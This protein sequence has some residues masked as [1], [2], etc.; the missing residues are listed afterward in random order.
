[1]MKQ[2]ISK[3]ERQENVRQSLSTLRSMIKDED[4]KEL[5]YTILTTQPDLFL[6]TLTSEDAKTRK[7]AA[8]L[9]GDLGDLLS[10]SQI[11]S[12]KQLCETFTATLF[13]S[14]DRETTLFVKSAYLEA[15]KEYDYTG[16]LPQ[17]KERLAALSSM[18]LAE[19]NRKHITEEIH[20]LTDMIVS[21]EGI[22]KHA[23]TGFHKE[24]ECIFLTNRLHRDL[25]EGQL[26]AL[27][28][29]PFKPFPAGV[30]L[31]TRQLDELLP[32]RT[33][34]EVLFL[35]PGMTTLPSDPA[36]AAVK[37]CE[38]TLLQFLKERHDGT[39]PFYFRVEM[40]SKMPLDKK[41]QFI[42][43]FASE[44][45]RV[46]HRQLINSKANYELELRL[47][48]NKSGTYNTLL[49]LFTIND[50]RFS[51]RKE[52]LA[53]SMKPVN[54]ALLVAL[55]KPYMTENARVLDPFCGVGTLLIERQKEVKADT[56]YGLDISEEALQ[57]AKQNTKAAGQLVHYIHRDFQSFTHE[58]HF[59]EIFTDMPFAMGNSSQE[60]ILRLYKDFFAHAKTLLSKAGT[61]IVYTRNP[62][63]C[64]R[65]AK[66]NDF[67]ILKEFLI[68]EKED[69][70]LLIIK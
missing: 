39:S 37:A 36:L 26:A 67:R 52:F 32:V 24:N 66:E 19:D 30:R 11:P 48:A 60:D 1:M 7:N 25:V 6:S 29:T 33:Y 54:A 15:L 38:S 46:S 61:L 65:F 8:L 70:R 3:I 41:S 10:S 50:E 5:F 22:V 69:A 28:T 17:L 21:R 44:L 63:Y 20:V 43:R 51:Y 4:Q 47:I 16:L 42:H 23:F 53:S 45:E 14:Y 35:V 64:T 58:Y 68:S 56:S 59:D 9:I 55:A 62:A 12:D 40:K 57:K 2:L 13:Q 49:K 27:T 34:Q 31:V 18:E